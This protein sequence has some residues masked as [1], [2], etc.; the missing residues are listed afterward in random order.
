MGMG[1]MMLRPHAQLGLTGLYSCLKPIP[2]GF[3][4]FS[5]LG[6]VSQTFDLKNMISTYSKDFP[7]KKNGQ[8]LPDLLK[9]RF[10]YHQIFMISSSM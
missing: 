10:P 5:S 8:N 6:E 3:F 7:W 4:F 2:W 9:K 1:P